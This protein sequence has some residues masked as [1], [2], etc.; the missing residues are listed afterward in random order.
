[1]KATA[2]SKS[3]A[4]GTEGQDVPKPK[5]GTSSGRSRRP[6]N[7]EASTTESV[8]ALDQKLGR[9]IIADFGWR[10]RP[11]RGRGPERTNQ[12]ARIFQGKATFRCRGNQLIADFDSADNL[13]NESV[14]LSAHSFPTLYQDP[15]CHLCSPTRAFPRI[16][17]PSS[18]PSL[19]SFRIAFFGNTH[20]SNH[21]SRTHL[22]GHCRAQHQEGE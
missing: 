1:M 15:S 13:Y 6:R 5:S 3:S 12:K 17:V 10:M 11:W 19:P 2:T 14:N 9:R 16:A 20:T 21:V 22:L 4:V 18:R 8:S 7:Q